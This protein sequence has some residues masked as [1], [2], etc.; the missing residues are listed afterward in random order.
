MSLP[1]YQPSRLP[2]GEYRFVITDYE[3]RKHDGGAITV[4]FT[5][6]VEMPRGGYR[7]HVESI[8]VWEDRYRDLLLAIGGSEDEQGI[9]HLSEMQM[10][11][12]IGSSF[13]AAILHE[14]DKDDSSKTWA[15]VA[16]VRVPVVESL[17]PQEEED[18]PMP[19]GNN[20]EPGEPEDE[21]PF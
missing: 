19:S 10:A 14:Q 1:D 2:E 18:V 4:K 16:D 15:R 20:G 17:A 8:G 11:D 3:K 7:Q 21:I 12:V 9:P 5:F 6:K 13:K